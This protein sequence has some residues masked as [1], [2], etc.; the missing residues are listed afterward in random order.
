[1][2]VVGDPEGKM[3]ELVVRVREWPS[4]ASGYI[5]CCGV[6]RTAMPGLAMGLR[7]TGT[8][9]KAGDGEGC[10]MTAVCMFAR[11]GDP[12]LAGHGV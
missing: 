4:C 11:L 7:R 9:P 6:G 3:P 5:C 12:S 1:M 8:A 2:L 10:A